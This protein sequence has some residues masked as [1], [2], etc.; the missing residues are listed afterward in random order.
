M[1]LKWHQNFSYMFGG[2]EAATFEGV[3][4]GLV[5]RK[6]PWTWARDTPEASPGPKPPLHCQWTPPPCLFLAAWLAA[7]DHLNRWEQCYR[8]P[9]PQIIYNLH[10]V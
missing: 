3:M 10:L 1:C 8:K 9:K 5:W 2:E 6:G 4:D 7:Y